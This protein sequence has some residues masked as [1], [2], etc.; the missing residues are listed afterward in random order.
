MPN[1]RLKPSKAA[2][3]LF[4]LLGGKRQLQNP[5]FQRRFRADT[6]TPNERAHAEKLIAWAVGD[7][8]PPNQSG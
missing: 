7:S 6:R 4:L 8:E 5:E 3:L 2:T 1:D